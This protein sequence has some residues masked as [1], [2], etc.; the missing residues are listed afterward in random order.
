MV[1]VAV[2]FTFPNLSMVNINFIVFTDGGNPCME[3]ANSV[4]VDYAPSN[5]YV[6]GDCFWYFPDTNTTDGDLDC[7]L[8][9]DNKV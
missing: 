9:G 4:G 7:S 2:H 8:R 5:T 1:G 6:A 3:G